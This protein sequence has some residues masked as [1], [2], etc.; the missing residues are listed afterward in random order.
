[1]SGAKTK[2]LSDHLT[3]FSK[4]FFEDGAHKSSEYCLKNV[5]VTVQKSFLKKFPR[6]RHFGLMLDIQSRVQSLANKHSMN[7]YQRP[8]K[9]P[10]RIRDYTVFEDYSK[11]NTYTELHSHSVWFVHPDNAKRFNRDFDQKEAWKSQT[12]FITECGEVINLQEVIHSVV[13][14]PIPVHTRQKEWTAKWFNLMRVLDYN[15]K[16]LTTVDEDPLSNGISFSLNEY[17]GERPKSL[18]NGLVA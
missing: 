8:A 12:N 18:R 17:R 5:N 4:M 10:Y 3:R 6:S 2:I 9:A 15:L 13:I 11:Y 14:Q 1:M 16:N 7:N